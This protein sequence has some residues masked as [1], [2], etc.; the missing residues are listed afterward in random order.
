[1]DREFGISR[2]ISEV[3]LP[4]TG[5]RFQCAAINHMEKTE[6]TCIQ[7]HMYV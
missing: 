3:L 6:K 5:S 1:M 4:S 2:W 7:E